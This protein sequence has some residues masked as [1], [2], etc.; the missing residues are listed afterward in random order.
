MELTAAVKSRANA[1][2]FCAVGITRADPFEEAEAAATLRTKEGLMDGLSWWSE[3][4]VHASANPRRATPDARTVIALAFPYPSP[5]GGGQ[6]GGRRDGPRGR[7]AAY[8]LGRD[9]HEVL[10]ERM[11]PLL[12]MLRERGYTAKTYVDHGW[13]LDRAAAARAGIGWLGKNTTPPL[14]RT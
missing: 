4:R 11:Q 3:A 14:P 13:M 2:G 7:I 10:I 9:Y 1:L 6:G 5:S 8:A 12:A